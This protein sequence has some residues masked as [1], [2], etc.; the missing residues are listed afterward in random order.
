MAAVYF[1]SLKDMATP[2]SIELFL[3]EGTPGGLIT[4]EI[5]GW[6]GKIIA[7]P[8]QSLTACSVATV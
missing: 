6:T 3:A 7:A 4:A 1:K 8:R 2:R 5:S